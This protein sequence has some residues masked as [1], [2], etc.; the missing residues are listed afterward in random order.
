VERRDRE[1]GRKG[2]LMQRKLE[3]PDLLDFLAGQLEDAEAQWSLG[4]FGAIAEFMRDP[5]EPVEISRNETSVA[6]V[7]ARGGIRIEARPDARL[8]AFETVTTQA[9]SQRVALC[10]AERAAAM[11]QRAALTELGPDGHAL[12]AQDRG[13]I[14][15]DLGLGALQVDACVRAADPD[16]AARLRACAGRTLFAPDNPAMGLILSHGPHRV[17]MTRC[18]RAEVYQA[19]PAPGGTS[20]QGPHTHVLPKL[21]ARRRTHAATESI[22][23]GFVSCAHLYPAHPLRDGTGRARP[24]D[25]GRHAAFQ[26][27]LSRYGDIE[28]VRLKRNV[29]KAVVSGAGP[30]AIAMPSDRHAQAYV[31]IALRQFKASDGTS[32]NLTAWFAA[33]D[34]GADGDEAELDER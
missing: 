7:T 29:T 31:R 17:F 6:A 13:A 20:P 4:T 23:R 16:L 30:A 19:I 24:F 21:L 28:H 1:V 2:E 9:W 12:R 18:G 27:M 5:D 34:H 25:G 15:F 10:L 11:G 14:L 26:R 33:H 3:V 8:V 32:P 22:P